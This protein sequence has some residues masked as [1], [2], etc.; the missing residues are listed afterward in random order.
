MIWRK[1]ASHVDDCYFFLVKTYGYNAKNR[2]KI[3]YPSV[4]SIIIPVPHSD[5]LLQSVFYELP[6][7]DVL[8]ES[9]H[10]LML[11]HYERPEGEDKD[12]EHLKENLSEND[13]TINGTDFGGILA[14]SSTSSMAQPECFDQSELNDLVAC[15]PGL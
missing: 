12:I 14:I 8:Q 1:P 2:N 6:C 9:L 11:V 5:E 7:N 13:D 15:G 10:S 4:L 3:V